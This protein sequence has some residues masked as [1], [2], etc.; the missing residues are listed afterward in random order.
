MMLLFLILIIEKGLRKG[1]ELKAPYYASAAATRDYITARG[2]IPNNINNIVIYNSKLFYIKVI[3]FVGIVIYG[4]RPQQA[5]LL[6]TKASCYYIRQVAVT[7]HRGTSVVR[8][9]K[10]LTLFYI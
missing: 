4:T 8:N 1:E 2:I 5:K 7:C 9:L 6:G 3:Y 10:F